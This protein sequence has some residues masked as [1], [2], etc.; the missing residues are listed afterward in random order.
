MPDLSLALQ[1]NPVLFGILAL[2]IAAVSYL[3]YRVTIP[4]IPGLLKTVLIFLRTAGLIAVLMIFFEPVLTVVTRTE[5]P[6]RVALLVDN[7]RSMT[8]VDGAG[9]RAGIV[10]RLLRNEVFSGL[11]RQNKLTT[12]GFANEARHLAAFHP[13]S[14]QLDGVATNIDASIKR[15]RE[16]RDEENIRLGILISDGNYNIGPRPVYEAERLGLPLFTVGIG[17]SLEQKDL[18]ISRVM[19]NEIVYLDT[20]SPV[21]VRVRS[22]GFGGERVSVRLSDEHDVVEEKMIT[23][24]EGTHDY[25]L[26]FAFRP[27]H[28]GTERYTVSVQELPDEVTYENNHQSFYVRVID[29][30]VRVLLL[31][32]AP[33]QDI[34]FLRRTLESDETIEVILS[35]QSADGSFIGEEPAD[36]RLREADLIILAGF[37]AN[38]SP[39]D[40]VH[41]VQSVVEEHNKPVMFMENLH[42]DV[43]RI[44]GILPIV[45]E[46]TRFEESRTFVH[47]PDEQSAH[48][49]F[50]SG[51]ERV[52]IDWNL[53]PPVYRT[54]NRYLVRPGSEKLMTH[55]MQSTALDDP[56][57]V[58]RSVGGRKS[59]AILG[60]GVWR[61]R[62]MGRG[63]VDGVQLYDN[64]MLNLVQWLTTDEDE[65]RVR[66]TASKEHYHTG[67]SIEFVGQVYDEQYR[68]LPNA[69]IR[70]T[71]R[72]ADDTYE[73][74]LS[75]RGHG[76]YEGSLNP[77]PAGDYEYLGSAEYEGIDI[78][79]DAGR[80]LVGE[81]NLEYRDTRMNIGVMRQ[82]AALTGGAYIHPDE[83]EKIAE[84]VRDIETFDAHIHTASTSYQVWNL[85]AAL[86]T[87]II[88]F[89]IEW[90]LRKRN[91]ML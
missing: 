44:D 21:D 20:E 7:S 17:D 38:Q 79:T 32:G 37:P 83:P 10:D 5:T 41:S 66:I 67:E 52:N 3:M 14:F 48:S 75:P 31:A 2:I 9:D 56:F 65:D 28:E 85:P 45:V 84:I 86:A 50:R 70:V 53:L 46:R 36:A 72:S 90:F 42:A 78:G 57:L 61:W 81:L 4:P 34:V 8:L 22:S 55:R 35:V 64:L 16:L 13:D 77:L 68:P 6:P 12:I 89:S 51:E 1:T 58:I 62:M 47:V 74:I 73:T 39:R 19:A 69:G 40:L 24:D 43:Q 82:L 54:M 26:S 76:R 18:L 33:T 59:A 27:Q 88:L 15:L 29:R 91:G 11:E 49:L 25:E 63:S 60:Y 23:L 71:V 87:L 30:K 80:F